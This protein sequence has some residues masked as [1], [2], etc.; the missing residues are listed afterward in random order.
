MIDPTL[1]D[2]LRA[3][4]VIDRGPGIKE[5]KIGEA[6]MKA[7]RRCVDVIEGC[8]RESKRHEIADAILLDA[9]LL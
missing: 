8:D 6:L 2:L 5:F 3:A 1:K 4:E 7:I 9:G